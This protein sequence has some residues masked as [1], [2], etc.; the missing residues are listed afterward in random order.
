MPLVY[1]GTCAYAYVHKASPPLFFINTHFFPPL[2]Q[3]LNEGLEIIRIGNYCGRG[4]S[5]II[6]NFVWF[7]LSLVSW[8]KSVSL[9]FFLCVS[10]ISS[11]YYAIVYTQLLSETF[12]T[13]LP[14][15]L[16]QFPTN[17]MASREWPVERPRKRR[18]MEQEFTLSEAEQGSAE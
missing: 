4:M 13:D 6:R 7:P 14:S 1:R 18:Y 9:R 12:E 3:F 11:A 10:L 8:S 15:L 2:D 5:R 16:S 17:E